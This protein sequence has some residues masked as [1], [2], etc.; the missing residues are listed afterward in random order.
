MP[1]SQATDDLLD[2]Y[3]TARDRYAMAR[4]AHENGAIVS[5]ITVT[6]EPV[7][8]GSPVQAQFAAYVQKRIPDTLDGL[9]ESVVNHLRHAAIAAKDALNAAIAQDEGN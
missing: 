1:F 2:A 9:S 7:D 5:A 8:P 6:V 3:R 4:Q